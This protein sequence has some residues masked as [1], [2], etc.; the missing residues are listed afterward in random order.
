MDQPTQELHIGIRCGSP[1][2][3]RERNA[4]PMKVKGFRQEVS[5]VLLVAGRSRRG[6]ERLL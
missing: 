3:S 1:L 5:G 4:R 2:A 6:V